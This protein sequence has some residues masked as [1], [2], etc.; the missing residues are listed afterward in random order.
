MPH[1]IVWQEQPLN[2]SFGACQ[3]KPKTAKTVEHVTVS[4]RLFHTTVSFNYAAR[5]TAEQ[6]IDDDL[7]KVSGISNR[8]TCLLDKHP[9]FLTS[10]HSISWRRKP[11]NKS[12]PAFSNSVAVSEISSFAQMQTTHISPNDDIRSLHT[13]K[14][15]WS[16]EEEEV[17]QAIV[18]Q[19][20][21]ANWNLIAMMMVGRT[22]KQCRERWLTKLSPAN[23]SDAWTPEEDARLIQLQS[24]Y[25][26]QWSKFKEHLP[27]RSTLSIKN[28][29]V[30]LRRRQSHTDPVT[31]SDV[32]IA[33][34]VIVDEPVENVET[35]IG[36]VEFG[37]QDF[38]DE[39]SWYA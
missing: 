15:R 13:P 31:Q 19:R 6:V 37:A 35:E 36:I 20:G 3:K 2:K 30:S 28:R 11:P 12:R 1:S 29:W 34:S 7:T 4:G 10:P 14:A 8:R 23:S 27:Q 22:G 32:R 17:L 16:S 33:G 21:P 39:F 9:F 24:E 26:N 38:F 18:E 5:Q 25:G